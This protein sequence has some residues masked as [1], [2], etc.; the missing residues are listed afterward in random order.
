LAAKATF[1][2]LR[3]SGTRGLGLELGVVETML[4]RGGVARYVEGGLY[5]LGGDWWSKDI[6]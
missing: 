2:G 4:L 5:T 6:F 1:C 3:P